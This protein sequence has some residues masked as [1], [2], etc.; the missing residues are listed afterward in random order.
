MP[1][2]RN[3]VDGS[4]Q[5]AM[6]TNFYTCC[7]ELTCKAMRIKHDLTSV[8]SHDGRRPP[9]KRLV[10]TSSRVST[11]CSAHPSYSNIY[12]AKTHTQEPSIATSSSNQ[13]A[14]AIQSW[15]D[16]EGRH[17]FLS[18][19]NSFVPSLLASVEHKAVQRVFNQAN[20]RTPRYPKKSLKD[21]ERIYGSPRLDL[22]GGGY[23]PTQ[24]NDISYLKCLKAHRKL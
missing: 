23:Y 11:D 17:T 14:A 2:S 18:K 8:G 16:P 10:F 9:P 15:E 19:E 12:P 1:P 4:V 7:L 21:T 22:D 20:S 6:C 13:S 5:K 3:Q 24:W